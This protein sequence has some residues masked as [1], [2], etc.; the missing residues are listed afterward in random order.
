MKILVPI[1]QVT[2]PASPV[3][4]NRDGS[5]VDNTDSK[6]VINPFDEIALEAAMQLKESGHASEVIVCTIGPESWNDS[7]RT[8]LAMGADRAIRVNGPLHLEPL[9]IARLLAKLAPEQDCSLVLA[10][11]QAVDSDDN[12]VGQMVAGLLGWSQA[13]FAS[14][15]TLQEDILRVERET[16]S[17]RE[18]LTL[19]LPA[20]ITTDLRLNTPR[21]A[22]LPN[23]VK[24]KR[25]PLDQM[26]A[27]DLESPC[28]PQW[29]VVETQPP[30]MR[31]MGRA[32]ASVDELHQILLKEGLIHGG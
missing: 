25:K 14:Q 6:M 23:I 7:L 15:I 11:K 26:E 24:A 10:G 21:Y 16:D 18:T 5:G 2:D 12:Q 4:L 17:G 1:K 8:A 13:T 31:P 28:T 9:A 30:T 22:S 29:H 27:T 19:P 3:R 32:V 20:V